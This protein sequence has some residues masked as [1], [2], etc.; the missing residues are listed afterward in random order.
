MEGNLPLE[1]TTIKCTM[2][3]CYLI[4]AGEGFVLIDTGPSFGRVA[5]KK[6]LN[7]AGCRP[8]DIKLILITHADFDHTG[9]CAWLQKKYGAPI[10]IHRD[11]AAAVETGRMFLNRKNQ[12]RKVASLMVYGVALIVFRRFKPDVF[13]GDGDDLSLYGL[14]ANVVHLPGHST[15]SIGV[16]TADGDLFCGDLLIT[17][18]GKPVKNRLV[19]D[20]ADMNAS[21]ERIKGMGVKIIYPGHGRPFG[22][23][24]LHL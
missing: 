11:E 22:I 19:D 2:V 10:A 21:I 15:G 8:G 17:S 9:N 12:S 16:R 1:I 23:E 6:A 20:V 4:K 14:N 5:L 3:N 18:R 13:L 24:E 7:R